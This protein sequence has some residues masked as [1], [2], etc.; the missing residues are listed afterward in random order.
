MR[1]SSTQFIG[2][3]IATAVFA[4][5][6]PHQTGKA[7]EQQLQIPAADLAIPG[8]VQKSPVNADDVTNSAANELSSAQA[9]AFN[10]KDAIPHTRG[11]HDISL[12]RDAAPSV[13]LILANDSLGSGS[14]IQDN[15]VLTNFH[16]FDHNREVTVVFKP[17]DPSGKAAQDEIVKGDVVKVD[18]QRDL[19]LVRPRS[20]PKRFMRPLEIS[21]KDIEVGADVAAICHPKGEDWT[22]TKG[23]VSSIRPD[24]QWSYDNGASHRA[25][26]IQTQTPINPGNSGGPLLSETGKIVGINS[27]G[28][29]SA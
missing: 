2:L 27:F 21:V 20:F 28:D 26:V 9:R 29:K 25:T 17:T 13:L 24:Y 22:F 23:I 5:L 8:V 15:L 16:V 1:L 12:F 10:F 3:H 11:V 18:V 6:I 7:Q 19:A 4:V 14:L